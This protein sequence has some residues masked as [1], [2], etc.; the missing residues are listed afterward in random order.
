MVTKKVIDPFQE[1]LSGVRSSEAKKRYGSA[2]ALVA[3]SMQDPHRVYPHMDF[4]VELLESEH[5]ILTWNALAVIANLTKVDTQKRF[6]DIFEKYYRFLETGYMVTAANVIGNSTVIAQAK[7]YLIPRITRKLLKVE[8]LKTGPHLTAECKRVLAEK[9]IDSFDTFFDRVEQ[10]EN[11]MRFV[12]KCCSSSRRTLKK[13]AVQ[14]TQK[15][16]T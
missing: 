6:D 11:V 9:V 13:K 4:F 14:F 10:K 15:W 2:K 7:P 1:L 3:L 8:T 12:K 16:G 5:R